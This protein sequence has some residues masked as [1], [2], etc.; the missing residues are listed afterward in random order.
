MEQTKSEGVSPGPPCPQAE[1]LRAEYH[2][3]VRAYRKAVS[4][5]DAHLPPQEFE[6][7]YHR[8]E[9][10]RAMFEQRREELL[11]HVYVHGCQSER[12]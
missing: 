11:Q 7:A 6:S 9:E 4:G 3:A 8:A 10:A 2:R 12:K 5:L 1:G